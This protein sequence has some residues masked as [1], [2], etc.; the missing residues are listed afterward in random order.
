MAN[1]L[2]KLADQDPTV[3]HVAFVMLPG[4]VDKIATGFHMLKIAS[5]GDFYSFI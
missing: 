2:R 1:I 4:L 3:Y 5:D